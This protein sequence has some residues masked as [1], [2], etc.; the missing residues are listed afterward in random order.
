MTQGGSDGRSNLY[1][2]VQLGPHNVGLMDGIPVGFG[3]V[4]AELLSGEP[5]VIL[6]LL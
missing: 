6:I 3:S 1:W 5:V 2:P 4:T